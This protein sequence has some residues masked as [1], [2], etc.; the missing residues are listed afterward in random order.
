MEWFLALAS[1]RWP[2]P[3]LRTFFVHPAA[4]P[5]G[6]PPSSS[7]GISSRAHSGQSPLPPAGPATGNAHSQCNYKYANL[8]EVQADKSGEALEASVVA[9]PAPRG[10]PKRI[11]GT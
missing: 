11:R 5:A 10:T 7:P 6:H 2:R 9:L 3:Q 4:Y 1:L 8:W